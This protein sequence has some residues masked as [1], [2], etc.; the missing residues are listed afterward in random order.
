M[1]LLADENIDGVIIRK[2]RQAGHQVLS[3]AEMFPSISDNEVLDLSNSSAAIL[4]TADR[5]FGNSSFG[6]GAQ[7]TA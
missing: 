7:P 6:T 5:D 1:I 2:L 3:V 4:L